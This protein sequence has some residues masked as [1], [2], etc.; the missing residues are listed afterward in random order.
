M[1]ADGTVL[2]VCQHYRQLALA[3]LSIFGYSSNIYKKSGVDIFLEIDYND[4]LP[5][6]V[7]S[8]LW[9]NGAN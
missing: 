3:E 6:I 5:V 8:T 2:S 7:F 9:T 1:K 4:V